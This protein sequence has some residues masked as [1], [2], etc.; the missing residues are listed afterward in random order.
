MR[1]IDADELLRRYDETHVGEPG[2]ARR[3][4]LEA[5]TIEQEPIIPNKL[6]KVINA[7]YCHMNTFIDCKKC[8]YN[9]EDGG[10]CMEKMHRDILTVLE[11]CKEELGVKDDA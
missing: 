11:K 4:I 6:N 8:V 10:R 7:L 1:L 2:N 3:L 9:E 5:P